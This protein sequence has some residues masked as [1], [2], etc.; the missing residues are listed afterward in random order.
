MD[1][2]RRSQALRP[3]RPQGTGRSGD[4]REAQGEA[5]EQEREQSTALD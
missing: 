1:D 4:G 2:E 5:Q 3:S